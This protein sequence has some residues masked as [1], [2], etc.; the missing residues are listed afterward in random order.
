MWTEELAARLQKL[1][2]ENTELKAY[3]NAAITG[4]RHH[5]AS[6]DAITGELEIAKMPKYGNS[7]A[8]CLKLICA[9]NTA[10][11]DLTASN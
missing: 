9:Q 5:Y 7:G 3:L 11:V 6:S 10:T 4:A 1:E 8:H 2:D